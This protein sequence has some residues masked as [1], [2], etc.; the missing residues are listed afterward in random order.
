M[1]IGSAQ[2]QLE[3]SIVDLADPVHQGAPALFRRAAQRPF[4]LRGA[5]GPGRRGL[6]GF[7]LARGLETQAGEAGFRFLL[8]REGFA[9]VGL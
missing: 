7:G 5:Q 9:L 8:A 2:T 6:E 4:R 3:L 1:R